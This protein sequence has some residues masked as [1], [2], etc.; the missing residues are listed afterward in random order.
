M[1][2]AGYGLLDLLTFFTVGPKEARAW[3]VRKG[4]RGPEAAGVIH[5]DFEKGFI[6]AETI[7]YN[8]YVAGKGEAGARDAGKL[9]LGRQ[10]LHRAGWRC[11]ALPLQYLRERMK[12]LEDFA[13][14]QVMEFPPRTVSEDEIIAFARDYDPQPFHLD[15]EAAK[16]SLFGGLCASGWHTAS[17]M[18]RMLVDHMIGKYASMG[19]PGIDQLRW[20]K[21]VFPGDTLHL[22]GE[23]LEVKFS[24]SKPDRG[25]IT[26]RYEMTNQKGETVLTMQGKGMYAR[27][28]AQG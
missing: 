1:I 17:M 2:R 27:R 20:V 7:A 23:V 11:D 16:Q 6:R 12:Y 13:V 10:R 25:V 24:Q 14:G 22:R 4:A 3:T 9:R 8:D 5:T 18:M 26:T 15:K 19:S 28:P 21:P